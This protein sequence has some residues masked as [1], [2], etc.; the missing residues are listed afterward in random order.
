MQTYTYSSSCLATHTFYLLTLFLLASV[1]G[2]NT[3]HWSI[4]TDLL[5]ISNQRKHNERLCRQL[6]QSVSLNI[7]WCMQP[8]I[9]L[10]YFFEVSFLL[11]FLTIGITFILHDL[12]R[13]FESPY[14]VIGACIRM[15]Q[16]F[17][18]LAHFER[19]EKSIC[20]IRATRAFCL[21]FC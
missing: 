20:P 10:S 19:K 14:A 9:Y 7:Y 2:H 1:L 5:N 21:F 11:I 16:F 8:N 3:I 18:S 4:T 15:H 17:W 13:W 6:T 12:S